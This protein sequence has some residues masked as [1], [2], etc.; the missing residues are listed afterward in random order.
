VDG[1]VVADSATATSDVAV[2]EAL[3]CADDGAAD[4]DAGADGRFSGEGAACD[5]GVPLH[6]VVRRANDMMTP[7][8]ILFMRT[9]SALYVLT[10]QNTTSV[11]STS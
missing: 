9:I 6:P 3:G 11:L 5:V 1:H 10:K 2:S 4:E 8:R 7:V